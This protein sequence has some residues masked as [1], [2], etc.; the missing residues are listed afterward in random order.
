MLLVELGLVV[1]LLVDCCLGAYHTGVRD[2]DGWALLRVATVAA[3]SVDVCGSLAT[4]GVV[5]FARPL[6][7]LL[8]V[9]DNSHVKRLVQSI[10][11]TVPAM[12]E[13]ALFA[14]VVLL[15]FSASSQQLLYDVYVDAEGHP[16]PESFAT[17]P[18]SLLTHFTLF[19]RDNWAVIA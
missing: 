3:L 5:R 12:A 9:C 14:L 1:V 6:R 13:L 19:T 4:W 18:R 7:P 17:F 8:M 11:A 10:G 15:V 16:L 2:L